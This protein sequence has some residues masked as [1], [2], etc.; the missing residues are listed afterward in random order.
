MAVVLID[1]QLFT[2][3]AMEKKLEA[4]SMKRRKI[5]EWIKETPGVNLENITGGKPIVSIQSTDTSK[6]SPKPSKKRSRKKKAPPPEE[7]EDTFAYFGYKAPTETEEIRR[8][9]FKRVHSEN[10]ILQSLENLHIGTEEITSVKMPDN[11]KSLE[12]N[13]LNRLQYF[14][15]QKKYD[16][17]YFRYPK[18]TSLATSFA[19]HGGKLIIVPTDTRIDDFTFA[20][21]P[22]DIIF[23]ICPDG[24]HRS[25]VLYLV[26]QGIKRMTG[27]TEG[28]I[29]PHGSIRGYDPYS[30]DQE[31]DYRF[32]ST[33]EDNVHPVT[34]IF[35]NTF[36][37]K[38]ASRFGNEKVGPNPDLNYTRRNGGITTPINS[39]V[40]SK[41]RES[42][43]EYFSLYYYK[44][45]PSS[46]RCIYMAFGSAVPVVLRRIMESNTAQELQAANCYVLALPWTVELYSQDPNP[47]KLQRA[48]AHYASFFC[49]IAE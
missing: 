42:M 47:T 26:L 17:K 8:P 25:Q 32:V 11:D 15:G 7:E 28:I 10:P 31:A 40:V 44:A 4:E 23:P 19:E 21:K 6:A 38:K 16:K 29:S 24:L 12:Y 34:R 20:I 18:L 27:S 43:N 3:I 41:L 1:D 30:L 9:A 37:Q 45:K 46:G 35:E 14:L 22:S 33:S 48:Y 13:D 5:Q 39:T 36:G 2:T 49:P